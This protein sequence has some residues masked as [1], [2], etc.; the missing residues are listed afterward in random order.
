REAHATRCRFDVEP[1]S[2][3]LDL[4]RHPAALGPFHGD[5]YFAARGMLND[6]VQG[7]LRNPVSRKPCRLRDEARVCPLEADQYLIEAHLDV[8]HVVELI[9]QGLQAGDQTA[10][11]NRRIEPAADSNEFTLDD[12]GHVVAYR[13]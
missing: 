12:L 5:N 7:L 13:S 8:E 1:R 6:V 3:V 10:T 4:D 2:R 11:D 9:A